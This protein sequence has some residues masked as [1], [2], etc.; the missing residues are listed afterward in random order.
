MVLAS[1]ATKMRFAQDGYAK[2]QQ[3]VLNSFLLQS[4]LGK[5][6]DNTTGRHEHYLV[7]RPGQMFGQNPAM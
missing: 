3:P 4:V 2:F 7:F 1:C 5:R 6:R